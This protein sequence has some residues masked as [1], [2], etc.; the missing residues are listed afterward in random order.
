M[1][2]RNTGSAD[3]YSDLDQGYS[4]IIFDENDYVYVLYGWTDEDHFN[5]F[6]TWFKV[7]KQIYISQWIALTEKYKNS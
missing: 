7:K 3:W 5:K 4:V 2:K 6:G 1:G